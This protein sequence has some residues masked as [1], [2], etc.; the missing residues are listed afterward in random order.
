MGLGFEILFLLSIILFP[1][2]NH[3]YLKERKREGGKEGERKEGKKQE[4]GP[5]LKAARKIT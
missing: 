1:V 5:W 4:N 2:R 3:L